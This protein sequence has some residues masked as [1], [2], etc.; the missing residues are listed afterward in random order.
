M[1]RPGLRQGPDFL[2]NLYS[3]GSH[4]HRHQTD[5]S[6][7]YIKFV[8]D[9]MLVLFLLCILITLMMVHRATCRSVHI[10]L[11]LKRDENPEFRDG[12][13]CDSNM[14]MFRFKTLS[15]TCKYCILETS[16]SLTAMAL[17]GSSYHKEMTSP[18]L[19]AT[20]RLRSLTA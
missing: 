11:L 18:H 12:R 6:G 2:D 4:R 19:M 1:C 10:V 13:L 17:C 5:L 9:A 15:L 16:F 20:T 3:L 7:E 8:E 14:K